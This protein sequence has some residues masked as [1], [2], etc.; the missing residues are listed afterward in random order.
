[1]IRYCKEVWSPMN[2]TCCAVCCAFAE[3]LP[4][5]E[6]HVKHGSYISQGKRFFAQSGN[7]SIKPPQK[8]GL[9]DT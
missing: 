3:V 7:V 5:H 6:Q 9:K 1:M 2:K 4:W 8:H